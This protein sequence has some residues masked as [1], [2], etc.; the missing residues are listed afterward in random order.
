[1]TAI[2]PAIYSSLSA[3]ARVRAAIAATAREDEAELDTLRA[4][5]PK[6]PFLVSDP[7]YCETMQRIFTLA[8]S[9]E[10]ELAGFALDFIAASRL[11]EPAS[12]Q[13]AVI[14]AASIMAS[15]AEL[16]TELGIDPADMAKASPARHNTVSTLLQLSKGKEE[17]AIV[18]VR[19]TAMRDF[20]SA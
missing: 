5:C 12:I 20:L 7:A 11:E 18:S 8:L 3:P 14:H 1:M 15:W 16:L 4:T 17:D 19:L 2:S 10:C 13:C 9:N 6:L